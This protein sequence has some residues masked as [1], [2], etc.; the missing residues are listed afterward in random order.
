MQL[1]KKSQPYKII[2]E[3]PKGITRSIDVKAASREV[4]EHRAL[5]RNPSATGVARA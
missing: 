5:K 1:Q 2:L 4:A 3:F